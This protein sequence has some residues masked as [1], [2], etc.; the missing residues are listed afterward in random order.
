M[1]KLSIEGVW[2]VGDQIRNFIQTH[3]EPSE[4][5]AKSNTKIGLSTKKV[6]VGNKLPKFDNYLT[7]SFNLSLLSEV[8]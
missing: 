2:L 6:P 3:S 4:D 8:I 7:W 5:G 1:V